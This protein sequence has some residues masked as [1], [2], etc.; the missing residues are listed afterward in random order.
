MKNL[1]TLTF[2]FLALLTYG[3]KITFNELDLIKSK[4]KL[5]VENK[6]KSKNFHFLN[7]QVSSTQWVSKNSSDIIQFNG[8][9]VLV[10]LTRN[11]Q[12]YKI[13]I[14]DLK[15]SKYKYSGKSTKNNTNIESYIK[16]KETIFL[17]TMDD[18][19][20]GKKVYSITFI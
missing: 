12:L 17:S 13:F 1:L 3:Q 15:K 8:K 16:G 11:Y 18:S 2:V 4:S 5:E 6:L 14:T 20:S 10:Y 7:D 19:A 9:G